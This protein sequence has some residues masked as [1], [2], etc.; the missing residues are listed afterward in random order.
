MN[1]F[2]PVDRAHD[3]KTDLD[4]GPCHP[5]QVKSTPDTEHA[6]PLFGH[7]LEPHEE[8]IGLLD[9]GSIPRGVG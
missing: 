3:V 4:I 1:A 2:L 9:N 5:Y 8:S 7:R 6:E